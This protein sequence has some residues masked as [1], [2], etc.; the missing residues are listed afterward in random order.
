[1]KGLIYVLTTV[2]VFGLAFWAY[3]ENYA[4]QEVVRQTQALQR[5]IGAAQVRPPD[6]AFVSS[7]R[8]RAGGS[9]ACA[10]GSPSSPPP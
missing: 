9:G 3:R 5:S 6:D 8:C 10:A 4:T 7:E 2:F 1:M